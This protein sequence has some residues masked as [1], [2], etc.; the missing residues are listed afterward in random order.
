MRLNFFKQYECTLSLFYAIKKS[1]KY[2]F[3]TMNYFKQSHISCYSK[4]WE[5]TP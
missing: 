3:I 5:I 2:F 1:T 4:V